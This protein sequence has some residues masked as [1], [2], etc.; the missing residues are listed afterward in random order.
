MGFSQKSV[1]SSTPSAGVAGASARFGWLAP[2]VWLLFALCLVSFGRVTP[3]AA[4]APRAEHSFSRHSAVLEAPVQT[5]P[6]AKLLNRGPRLRV[7]VQQVE[8][9]AALAPTVSAQTGAISRFFQP[10]AMESAASAG[11]AGQAARAPP[12]NGIL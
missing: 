10:M 6:Q 3:V 2:F 8:A 4:E 9:P 11:S 7:L 5:A 1:D 12:T